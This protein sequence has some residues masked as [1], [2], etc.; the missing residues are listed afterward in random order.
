[1]NFLKS[2]V[3]LAAALTFISATPAFAN[4]RIKDIV[5]VQNVRDNQLVGYGLVVG[6]KGTGDKLR[7]IPFTE[8]SLKALMERMGVNVSSSTLKTADVAAVMVTANLPAYARAGSRIDV[9]VAAMG[10]STNLMGGTLA[11]AELKGLDGQTYAV[12]QGAVAI[13]GF[14]AKGAAAQVSRGTTTTGRIASGGIVEREVGFDFA[15]MR[16]LKLA[17]RNPDFTTAARIAS[18]INREI[19]P[20]TALALDPG[21]IELRVPNG[22]AG[23][24]VQL[25]TNVEQLPVDVDERARIIIDEASGTVV[26]GDDVKVSR[27]AIAQ[28]NLTI[29]ISET[30][31][32]S[33]PGPFSNGQTTVLPRTSINVD[34]GKGKH[35]AI[36]NNNVSLRD[37]VNGLNALG[38]TPRDLITILQSLKAAGALQA[39]IETL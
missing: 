30:P 12:A 13:S 20:E 2:T 1:M 17:L 5:D 7:N 35:L 36:V 32:A 38:V 27:V 25:V 16:T 31:V 10:D 21:T 14:E 24:M 37:L 33:Q 4:S 3:E 18:T 15:G 19:G 9:Q 22:Y 11:A 8:A 34:D 28:G 29:S 6:L 26:M 23:G 39:D